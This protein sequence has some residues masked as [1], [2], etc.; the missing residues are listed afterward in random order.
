MFTVVRSIEIQAPPSAVWPYMS[1]Q[2]GLRGWLDPSLEID[3]RVGG[4]YGLLGADGETRISG[5][6]LDIVPEGALMLSWMEEGAG[7]VHPARL[8]IMLS[9]TSEGTEV[10]ITHDGFAGIGK[11]SWLATFQAYERGA[12]RHD[13]LKRLAVLVDGA[14]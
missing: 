2:D 3:V 14:R 1:S 5:T 11:D 10:T 7:W 4:G 8:S 12:A 6:V 13:I 9:P